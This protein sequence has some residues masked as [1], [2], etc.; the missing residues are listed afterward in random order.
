MFGWSPARDGHL[1]GSIS[2]TPS[3]L[4]GLTEFTI[5]ANN[6]AHSESQTITITVIEELVVSIGNDEID[7]DDSALDWRYL[8][9][10]L[11]LLILVLV[12]ALYYANKDELILDAEP[13]NTSSKPD[14]VDGL[15]TNERPYVLESVK[16]MKPGES[17][18]SKELITINNIT[19]GLNIRLIDYSNLDDV[20]K[21]TL[22]DS[23]DDSHG[24]TMIQADDEGVIKFR[25]R[26]DD[27][28]QPSLTGGKYNSKLKIGR[29][30]VY[31]RWNVE[32]E[33]EL[34]SSE[35]EKGPVNSKKAKKEE[36]LA[37][38]KSRAQSIDFTTLGVATAD[39]RD[40]LQTIKGIGPFIEEKLNALGI[41]T[42]AQVGNMTS[43]IEEEVNEA[44]EF[45]PGRVKRDE[46]ANQAKELAKN[47]K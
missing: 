24:M 38:I 10:P 27:S 23:K 25:L 19:P 45:F 15:G 3:E 5:W 2:G 8:C 47:K 12:F 1:D 40:N 13:E 18:L 34:K 43:K 21:F 16:S 4:I 11:I 46:W 17:V 28:V 37:R 33:A 35:Q 22:L 39:D 31:L 32:I 42:F 36:E 6:S 29:E 14:F 44:I 26:F 7:D 20:S 9:L 41:Y 30:S